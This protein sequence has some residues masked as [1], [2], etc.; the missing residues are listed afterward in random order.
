MNTVITNIFFIIVTLQDN[1]GF[2][3]AWS[4]TSKS[5]ITYENGKIY[6]E[7]YQNCYSW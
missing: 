3:K 6:F 4:K 1:R 2:I 7:N 5:T